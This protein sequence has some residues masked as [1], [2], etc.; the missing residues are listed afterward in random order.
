MFPTLQICNV[1][2][3]K[4]DVQYRK[5]QCNEFSRFKYNNQSQNNSSVANMANVANVAVAPTSFEN[6][7]KNLNADQYQQFLN[8][9]SP[10]VSDKD[11]KQ[12]DD[13][14]G[15]SLSIAINSLFHSKLHWVVDMRASSHI[16]SHADAFI[17]M[18]PIQH[19]TVTLP[20]GTRIMVEMF[21]DVQLND[22]IL[23]K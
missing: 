6:F 14:T 22:D 20:N 15:I 10:N 8:I 16:C 17:S 19:T 4:H 18:R 7:V 13:N 1:R 2:K 12:F 23:L 9:C 3:S 11:Q 21:G 5:V